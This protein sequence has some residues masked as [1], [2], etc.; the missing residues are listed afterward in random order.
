MGMLKR[1]K[2]FAALALTV[3]V[4][5]AAAFAGSSAIGG[6]EADLSPVESDSVV[7]IAQVPAQADI[8]AL[9]SPAKQ[10]P[11]KKKKKKARKKAAPKKS[12]PRPQATTPPVVTQAPRQTYT[13]PQTKP[14]PRATAAPVD[15]FE[16][17]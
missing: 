10:A 3:A 8:P 5:F 1:P 9:S 11:A 16:E 14:R 7:R 4:G 6:A 2:T 17:F 15:E 12:T 13:P